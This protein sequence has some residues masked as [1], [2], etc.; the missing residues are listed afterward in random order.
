LSVL[1]NFHGF[2][3]ENL[4]DNVFPAESYCAISRTHPLFERRL[5]RPFVDGDSQVG[6]LQRPDLNPVDCPWNGAGFVDPKPLEIFGMDWLGTTDSVRLN[7]IASPFREKWEVI[8]GAVVGIVAVTAATACAGVF[9]AGRARGAAILPGVGAKLGA[10]ADTHGATRRC[11]SL[12]S[13][14][15]LINGNRR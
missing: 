14:K 8:T 10:A 5:R 6:L 4:H 11:N 2:A 12:M 13:R 15:S 9:S 7:W 3:I 1:P